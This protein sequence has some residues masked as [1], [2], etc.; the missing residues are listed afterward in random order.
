MFQIYSV[1]IKTLWRQDLALVLLG[2][3]VDVGDHGGGVGHEDGVHETAG[4][5]TDHDDPHLNII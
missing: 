4:H 1:I 2:G 5:H 3:R